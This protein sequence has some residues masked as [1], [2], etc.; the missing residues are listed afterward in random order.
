MKVMKVTKV[1]KKS[2][3]FSCFFKKDI[4]TLSTK[5]NW[6]TNNR[7]IETRTHENTIP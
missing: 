1:I 6:G 3:W 5:V 2:G 4:V 7:G